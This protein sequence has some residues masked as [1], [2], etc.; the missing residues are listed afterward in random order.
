MRCY[1]ARKKLAAFL[2]GQL[3]LAQKEEL[4]EHLEACL[5]CQEQL[6]DLKQ[7]DQALSVY[8]MVE[9]GV[10]F[11]PNFWQKVRNI[12]AKQ[13]KTVTVGVY[14][15]R[16][17]LVILF[18]SLAVGAVSGIFT[19]KYN[20]QEQYMSELKIDYLRDYPPN[21]LSGKNIVLASL[22]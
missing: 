18:L 14:F 7:L 3:N 17:A 9:T 11:V 22:R 12:E 21:S 2:D 13:V 20:A 15:Y 16:F 10:D 1:K 4:Q 19:A 5:N 8:P 6:A